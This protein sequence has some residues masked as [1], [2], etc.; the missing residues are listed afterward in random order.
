MIAQNQ[1][2]D[3]AYTAPATGA[4]ALTILATATNG[5]F[6]NPG[7]IPGDTTAP[8]VPGGDAVAGSYC[9][10]G[11]NPIGYCPSQGTITYTNGTAQSYY[12]TVPDWVSGPATLAAADMTYRNVP[13]GQQTAA[14]KLYPFSIPLTPGLTVQSVT[15]P[16]DT[17]LPGGATGQVHVFALGAR[18]TTTG[19]VEAGGSTVAATGSDTWTGAWASDTEGDYDYESGDFGNQSFRILVQPSVTGPTIRIKLDDALGNA[20]LDIGEATVA[21]TSGTDL[22]PTAAVTAAPTVLTFGGSQSTVIPEGGM[23]Y[24]DPLSFPVTAGQWLAVSFDLTNSVP[25]LP[26]HSW[27]D[28]VYEYATP[29]GAGNYTTATAATEYTTSGSYNGTFSNLVTELDVQTAGEPTQVV[30]GDNLI[31]AWENNTAPLSP[32][33]GAAERLAD[34][35]ANA[36]PTTPDPYG[37]L[38][39]GIESN[40]LTVDYPETKTGATGGGPIGGPSALSRIDRDV[41]DVPGIDTVVLDEGLED[42]LTGQSAGNL[43]NGLTDLLTDLSATATATGGA[44]INTVALGLTPCGGY[45]GDGNTG[46]G[47]NANDPCTAGVETVRTTV[48]DYLAQGPLSLNQYVSP[49]LFY[50]NPDTLIGI[51]TDNPVQV[52]PTAAI[53]TSRNNNTPADPVNLTN[54][55]MG[56]LANGILAAQDNW[57]LTDG[58][59][60]SSA[61]DYALNNYS[62]AYLTATDP[63]N[64]GD[65]PLTLNGTEGTNYSWP[66]ATVGSETGH[67]VLSLDGSTGYGTTTGPLLNTA[68]SFSISAWADLSSLPTTNAIIASQDG[69]DDSGFFFGYDYNSSNSPTWALFFSNTDSDSPTSWSVA[70]SSTAATGWTHLVGIY[71]AT[72]HTAQLYVNGALAD[73]V[74]GVTTWASSGDFAV[75]RDLSDGAAANLFPGDISDVQAWNYALTA[76]QISALYDQIQ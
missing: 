18:D 7:N 8:Y 36:S 63:N 59:G 41:L 53:G 75:G 25:D 6:S 11:T 57:A 9:F 5:G 15:L 40:Q 51:T 58:N 62:N 23:V 60:S 14:T 66:T 30:L 10:T 32:N 35:L 43:E 28:T 68:A 70:H 67:T 52:T 61:A 20:P 44:F 47:T 22:S 71:N 65:N 45:N 49:T 74:T 19:T 12:L 33:D 31:D 27:G 17:V 42:A 38:N 34:D 4:S 76:P 16:D 55:G 37:T 69:T 24:S 29:V 56:A 13:G 39:A 26:E 3:Y 2:V 46:T 73:T 21:A 64:A 72:S 1:V 54:A 48:N 50:V